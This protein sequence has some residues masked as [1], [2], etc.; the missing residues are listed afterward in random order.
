MKNILF[1][2]LLVVFI[3]AGCSSD[4][5]KGSYFTFADK[6]WKRFENP[7]IEFDI[8]K[9]GIFY[10]MWLEV[11]YD[12]SLAPETLPV[13]V[14]M[15]TPSGEVRSRTLNLKFKD[16]NENNRDGKFRVMLRKDFAFSEKGSCSFEFENR[17]QDIKTPGMIRIGIVLEKGI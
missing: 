4:A 7:E 16:Q 5:I 9:P 11:D 13:T 14:I 3:I 8:S 10:N 6:Q 17:S 15:Y 12:A 1:R 2:Y